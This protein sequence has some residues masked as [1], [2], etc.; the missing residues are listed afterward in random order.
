MYVFVLKKEREKNP[1]QTQELR[2]KHGQYYR[3][4]TCLGSNGLCVFV[5]MY[6][7]VSIRKR[8]RD[9]DTTTYAERDGQGHYY[10]TL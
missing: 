1:T 2:E 8:E 7:C 9:R 6:A 5:Y 3:Q 10:Y 4:C